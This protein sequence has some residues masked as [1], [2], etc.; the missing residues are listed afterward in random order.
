[1]KSMIKGVVVGLLLRKISPIASLFLTKGGT[2]QCQALATGVH[3]SRNVFNFSDHKIF[4]FLNFDTGWT[5]KNVADENFPFY[6]N[7]LH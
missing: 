5:G 6:G 1:M 7:I 2:I 4:V 3:M